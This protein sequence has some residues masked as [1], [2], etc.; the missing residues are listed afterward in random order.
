MKVIQTCM[1]IKKYWK[2]RKVLFY[3]IYFEEMFGSTC[4][5]YVDCF[6]FLCPQVNHDKIV[7][8]RA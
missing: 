6:F 5:Y 2:I 8:V 7:I 4:M 1:Y 3:F